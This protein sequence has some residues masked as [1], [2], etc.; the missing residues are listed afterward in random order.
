MNGLCDEKHKRVDE[1]LDTHERRLNAHSDQLDGL[2][3][4]DAKNTTSLDNLCK[5]IADLVQTVKW[6]IGLAGSSLIGFFFY[7]IQNGLF[8]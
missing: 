2:L 8:K 6:L 7:A 5:Q 1:R 4:S 3:V